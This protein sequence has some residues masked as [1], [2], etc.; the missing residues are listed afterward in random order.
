M[1]TNK[2]LYVPVRNSISKL[3]A[4]YFLLVAVGSIFVTFNSYFVGVH[5]YSYLKTVCPASASVYRYTSKDGSITEHEGCPNLVKKYEQKIN[6]EKYTFMFLFCLLVVSAVM[7]VLTI[8]PS[9][10]D[11]DE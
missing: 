8:R 6:A 9:S 11:K 4:P 10:S 5:S 1:H 7:F 3:L 2:L